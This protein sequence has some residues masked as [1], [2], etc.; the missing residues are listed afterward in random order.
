[1]DAPLAVHVI[2]ETAR[3]EAMATVNVVGRKEEK[4]R[5]DRMGMNRKRY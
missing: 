4:R 2:K 1:M 3:P 5:K